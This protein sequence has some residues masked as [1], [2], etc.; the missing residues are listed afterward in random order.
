MSVKLSRRAF[1]HAQALIKNSQCVLDERRDWSAHQPT[2]EEENRF[3]AQHGM[4][5]YAKWHLGE[6]HEEAEDTKARYKFPYGDFKKVHRCA[7]LSA[8]SRA[9]QY[10]HEDIELAAAHLHGM[11]EILKQNGVR[12]GAHVLSR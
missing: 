5:E 1:E 2:A 10:K 12:G 3:I 11:L 9:G 7:V 6:D 4:A 8:E